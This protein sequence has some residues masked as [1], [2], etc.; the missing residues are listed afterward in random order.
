MVQ[1]G[2][3]ILASNNFSKLKGKKVGL[4]L[5]AASV[6]SNLVSIAER[7]AD[8]SQFELKA[9]FGPQ[10]GLGSYTQANMIEWEGYIHPRFNVPVHSL[11]GKNREPSEKM[12]RGLDTVVIDL[13]DVGAKGYTYVWT[14]CLVLKACAK[15]KI[16]V[17][18]LDRPNP[19][20]GEEIEGPVTEKECLSF[21]GMHSIAIRHGMTLGELAKMLNEEMK[22]HADLEVIPMKEWKRSMYF[23]STGLPWVMPSPNMPTLD[24][25]ISYPG[26][27]LLEG[28]NISEGRGTTR[29]FEI[30]GAPYLNADKLCD[31][32]NQQNLGGIF[33]RPVTFLPTFDKY[34]S[35]PCEGG[36][37]HVTDRKLFRP[38][39]TAIAI[40]KTIQ[41]LNPKRFSFRKPPYEY[42][43]KK[44]PFDILAG[45]ETL[46][47]QIENQTPLSE[48]EKSWEK[49][50]EG[51]KKRRSDYL[52][53]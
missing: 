21:V 52:M 53:Y 25:A 11:Y 14:M 20:N 45:T 24:T 1:T 36:Q 22:L 50:I 16:G 35:D 23:D 34:C 32:L 42:E 47:E 31:E 43:K 28:T 48:I 12:L 19:I 7:F 27:E 17:M 5:S 38:V 40:V 44:L 3:E 18:V 51:F 9:L 30:F 33:F 26:M 39:R 37:I 8:S 46:K 49:G 2:F 13:Q 4:V 29:P 15:Q 41:Q 10:H 6:D